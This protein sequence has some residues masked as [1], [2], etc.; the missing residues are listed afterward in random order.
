VL[1][2]HARHHAAHSSGRA[3]VGPCAPAAGDA[4]D[5]FA[6]KVTAWWVDHT[7]R[8]LTERPLQFWDLC[9]GNFSI[10][11]QE[12]LRLGGFV[13]TARREDWELGYRVGLRGLP[14]EA[15]PEA[16]VRQIVETRLPVALAD[17]FDEG[18]G[19]VVFARRHPEILAWSSLAYW[20]DMPPQHRRAARWA[21]RHPD[22][23]LALNAAAVLGC[24][25]TEAAGLP[26]RFE[27]SLAMA[28]LIS[29]WAGVGVECG[30]ERG[31]IELRRRGRES[32]QPRAHVDMDAASE[33]DPPRP[34]E[35]A[36]I[37]VTF[38]GEALVALPVRRGGTPW[39]R[40]RFLAHAVDATAGYVGYHRAMSS[41]VAE[42]EL[43]AV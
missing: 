13:P 17:R 33:W 11:R 40:R 20:D 29:Y 23:R 21:M 14:I 31:W 28:T 41:A 15:N 26:R 18:R 37:I 5:L 25:A 7:N 34:G 30:G 6:R 16:A 12:F 4:G 38:R 2:A 19:D 9:T 24:A 36:E 32:E 1:L 43:V 27:Q 39:S 42:R 3:V 22:H 35:C 8:L 10:R